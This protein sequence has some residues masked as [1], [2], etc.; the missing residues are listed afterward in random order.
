MS[1]VVWTL[2]GMLR[3][4]LH[5]LL[6]SPLSSSLG[7]S[8]IMYVRAIGPRSTRL[9]CPLNAIVGIIMLRRGSTV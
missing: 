4:Y 2:Q 1:L 3:S 7:D 5:Q 6:C 9:K 8:R